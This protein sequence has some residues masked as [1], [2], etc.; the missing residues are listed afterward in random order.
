[1]GQVFISYARKDRSQ[2]VTLANLLHGFKFSTW[3]DSRLNA[4]QLFDDEIR[5]NIDACQYDAASLEEQV[6]TW[7]RFDAAY[8]CRPGHPGHAAVS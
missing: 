7:S 6:M 4:G 1:M 8:V 3:W 5:T 2:I